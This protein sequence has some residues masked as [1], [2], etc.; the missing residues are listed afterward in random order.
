MSSGA[1]SL[2]ASSDAAV[3]TSVSLSTKAPSESSVALHTSNGLSAPSGRGRM[4]TLRTR[5]PLACLDGDPGERPS[6]GRSTPCRALGSNTRSAGGGDASTSR[7]RFAAVGSSSSSSKEA[8]SRVGASEWC[9]KSS[10]KT[11]STTLSGR[12][13]LVAAETRIGPM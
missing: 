2:R 7:P 12:G 4:V 3:N 9:K 1:V 5:M 11:S 10:A 8:R 6:M 13:S